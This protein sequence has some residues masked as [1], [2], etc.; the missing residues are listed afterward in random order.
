MRA[1]AWTPSIGFVSTRIL[2]HARGAARTELLQ[3][4]VLVA[5]KIEFE[6]RRHGG[7]EALERVFASAAVLE[8]LPCI[9]NVLTQAAAVAAVE[10][11]H[12]L[13]KGALFVVVGA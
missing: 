11:D 3:L 10:V 13:R 7:Y 12:L 4:L 2:Q 5:A 9:G 8:E 6:A 1:A